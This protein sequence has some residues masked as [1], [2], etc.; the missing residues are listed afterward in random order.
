MNESSDRTEIKRALSVASVDFSMDRFLFRRDD[1]MELH[2]M[3][4]GKITVDMGKQAGHVQAEIA[5][6]SLARSAGEVFE[7]GDD[8]SEELAPLYQTIFKN[9]FEDPRPDPA[10]AEFGFT[11]PSVLLVNKVE[12]VA[13]YKGFGVGKA[14]V[15]RLIETFWR[16]G[17]IVALRPFPMQWRRGEKSLEKA[18][19]NAAQYGVPTNGKEEDRARVI[20]VW[21]S[22]GF[23][24][25]KKSDFWLLNP[26]T[27]P[28]PVAGSK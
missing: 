27:K 24:Q 10:L 22:M 4:T 11:R 18:V 15:S 20:A 2:S 13:E 7:L 12:I 14:A 6:F 28:V 23:R 19:E 16:P 21:E 1:W 25:F 17:W 26:T 9:P 8:A 5:R 3:V